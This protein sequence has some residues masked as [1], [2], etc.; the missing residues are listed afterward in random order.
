MSKAI[1]NELSRRERMRKK[2]KNKKETRDFP[3]GPVVKTL[4]PMK[5]GM[6]SIPGQ[7]TKIPHTAQ[8][9]KKKQKTKQTKKGNEEENW[10]G[11]KMSQAHITEHMPSDCS[12]HQGC[13]SCCT[14]E[15]G[16]MVTSHRRTYSELV[17]S[18]FIYVRS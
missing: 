17:G 4:L 2:I 14:Q 5:R 11:E 8:Q 12:Q 18:E 6:G 7:G 16:D 3:G 9:K 15:R 1:K 13:V 10:T